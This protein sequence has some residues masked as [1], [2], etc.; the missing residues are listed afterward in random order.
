MDDHRSKSR[1]VGAT[2]ALADAERRADQ[3]AC[4]RPNQHGPE[5]QR[6]PGSESECKQGWKDASRKHLPDFRLHAM[7]HDGVCA[8][9]SVIYVLT[10]E[11]AGLFSGK[12]NDVHGSC[13]PD[14]S[15]RA[16]EP[17][18]ELG[19]FVVAQSL[20]VAADR[21]KALQVE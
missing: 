2:P 3:Q 6:E 16:G 14:L 18:V 5:G 13:E 12:V 7:S 1:C 19:V 9:T 17:D 10:K 15:A 4:H 21:E 20:V 8:P 11:R